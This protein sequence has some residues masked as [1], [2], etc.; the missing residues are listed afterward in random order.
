MSLIDQNATVLFMGDSVTDCGRV[1]ARPGDLGQ[2]YP[3]KVA[4]YLS[5][6]CA[7]L[8]AKVIN[9]GVSGNRV[10][11]LAARWQTD[12]LDLRP[13][14][15][16]VLIGINDCWRRFDENDP[17]TPEA[18]ERDYRSI[19]GQTKKAGAKILLLEPFVLPEPPE[20]LGWRFDLDPKIQVAR[21]LARE[22]ADAF[23]PLDGLFA[24]A[25]NNADPRLYSADGVHPTDAGH[26][27][28]ARAWLRAAGV[29]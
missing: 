29:L 7:S 14:L 17:T 23:L 1:Y 18:F 19:L 26:A 15:V 6:F 22:Y 28:I 8:G 5:V 27:L 2:G 10:R 4:S 25:V 20:R 16:S 11:D 13:G 3:C 21:R 24:R 9:R 12:C